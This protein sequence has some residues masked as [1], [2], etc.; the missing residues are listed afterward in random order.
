MI[1]GRKLTNYV[2][3]GFTHSLFMNKRYL[4][5]GIMPI[6]LLAATFSTLLP[7]QAASSVSVTA[8]ARTAPI[9]NSTFSVPI[10]IRAGTGIRGLQ[11]DLAFNPSVVQLRT[12]TPNP[13]FWTI[14]NPNGDV[15]CVDAQGNPLSIDTQFT[16]RGTV[17]NT[18]GRLTA[19]ASAP[20]GVP[21][22]G[23]CTTTADVVM[24]TLLFTGT[25]NGT[26]INVFENVKIPGPNGINLL[27]G[28]V[29]STFSTSIGNFVVGTGASNTPTPTVTN[30]PVPPT[31]TAIPPTATSA[32]S[33]PVAVIIDPQSRPVG[34]TFSVPIKINAGT[35]IR[36]LQ[37]DLRF[38]PSV[39]QLRTITPNAAFWTIDNPNADVVCVDGQGNPLSI[40]TQFTNRG[41]VD[42]VNGRLTALASAP[43]GVPDGGSCTTTADVILATL[44]FTASANG[45]TINTFENVKIPGRNGINLPAGTIGGSYSATAGNFVIGTG[46]TNTATPTNTPVPATATNTAVPPTNTPVPATATKTAVPPTNTPV[47]PTATNTAV[48][49]TNTP[50]PA[51][52]TKTPMPPTATSLPPTATPPVCTNANLVP[53]GQTYRWWRMLRSTS[54]IN[55]AVE[56][57]LK[58]GDILVDVNLRGRGDDLPK[59]WEAAGV[60][61]DT[62]RNIG[63]MSFYNGAAD[64]SNPFYANGQFS[65]NVKMQ[66]T[67]D[68][69]TWVDSGWTIAPVYVDNHVSSTS[70]W[71]VFTGSPR[72][73]LG[74]RVVGQ[75]RTIELFSWHANV[76]EIE[77]RLQCK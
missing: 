43:L 44:I 55:R 17:N 53:S 4:L 66:Y 34:G 52:A 8:P 68:G 29:T 32:P 31:N 23:S 30:T 62:P 59:R 27:P 18:V 41:T 9:L 50:V 74:V 56:P 21:D 2:P 38:D 11:L 65:A 71:Y 26:S 72:N 6:I 12:I 20:L 51:T 48:P 19:F 46:I 77:A 16:N 64:S 75:V 45:T 39:V 5:S 67:T 76:N 70:K 28:D 1:T 57:R 61:W 7:A 60:I 40:D 35:G 33:A 47:P 49:P 42:N 24:A 63:T 37:L 10:T 25:A 15:V 73:V 36:G 54:D 58:D 69:S 3:I 22:G 14:D 13:A